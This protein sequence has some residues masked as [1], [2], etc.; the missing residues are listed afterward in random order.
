MNPD[1]DDS[2]SPQVPESVAARSDMLVTPFKYVSDTEFDSQRRENSQHATS[3]IE[4]LNGQHD[5][6]DRCAISIFCLLLST[7]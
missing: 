4:A 2:R 7:H 1:S 6:A 3:T 5:A